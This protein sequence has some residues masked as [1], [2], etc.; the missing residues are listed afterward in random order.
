MYQPQKAKSGDVENVNNGGRNIVAIMPA[1][2]LF[3]ARGD[4]TLALDDCLDGIH[5]EHERMFSH[6]REASRNHVMDKGALIG[7]PVLPI[8]VSLVGSR[9]VTLRWS[10]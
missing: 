10:K 4:A 6:P 5:R 1:Y 7:V 3:H 8:Q 9:P 2:L